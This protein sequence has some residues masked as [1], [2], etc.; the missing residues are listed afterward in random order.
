VRVVIFT[1]YYPPETG[2]PQN[3]LSHLA[4][5]LVSEGHDVDVV[6]AMPNYPRGQVSPAWRGKLVATE[7]C[8]GITVYR[9][10]IFAR[11]G[12][13]VWLQLLGYLSF[14]LSALATAPFRLRR[15][16]VV[17]WE[18]PPLFLA[19]TAFLLAR[20]L[21]AR[22]VMNVSD[23]WPETA[24]EMGVLRGRRLISIFRVLEAWAYGRADLVTYQTEGIGSGIRRLVPEKRTWFFPNGVDTAL[25][26]PQRPQDIG[27]EFTG[28]Q[29]KLV[30]GYAGNFGRGQAVDQIVAAAK[31]FGEDD[32]LSFVLV[33]DGPLKADVLRAVADSGLRSIAVSDPVDSSRMPA[34]LSSFDFAI[35]PL[36][37]LPVFSGARPSKMFELLAMG[38]PFI[39]CGRGEGADLALSSGA[40]IVVPPE[41]PDELAA[42]IA[43]LAGRSDATRNTMGASGRAYVIHHYDRAAIASR[44]ERELVLLCASEPRVLNSHQRDHRP[45]TNARTLRKEDIR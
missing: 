9:S 13:R 15:A 32:G 27:D 22:L 44:L 30:V 39:F 45:E 43:D 28:P 10:W 38:I 19:L 11:P 6:T 37:D 14:A 16:D 12:R 36:A 29:R 1:Q 17:L 2:A 21:G 23:L 40:A 3:R 25:F 8:D 4:S 20:R 18:S 41:R 26:A 34:L 42:A 31:E 33:G 7:T 5:Q 35:V 24:I